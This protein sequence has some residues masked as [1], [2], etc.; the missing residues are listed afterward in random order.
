MRVIRY[1]LF[2]DGVDMVIVHA[3]KPPIYYLDVYKAYDLSLPITSFVEEKS[4][5]FNE[6]NTLCSEE[7]LN[8]LEIVKRSVHHDRS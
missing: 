1:S 8:V 2:E 5:A 3:I 4:Q 6:D 7:Y